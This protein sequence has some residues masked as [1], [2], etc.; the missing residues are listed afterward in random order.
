MT[1]SFTYKE[2]GKESISPFVEST[3]YSWGETDKQQAQY[4]EGKDKKGPLSVGVTLT[5]T[6][7]A[8]DKLS[9]EARLVVFGDVNFVQNAF[10][11]IPGNRQIVLNAVA[12]LTEQENLI[13]LPPRNDHS[14]VLMLSSTQ[15][16]YTGLLIVIVLPGLVLAAGIA[17]W[18][19]RKKL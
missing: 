15:M 4:D 11:G 2:G 16:N 13:H 6:I 9:N 12:W 14:D 8:K 7:D 1:R 3:Q 5:K 18:I 10:V 19:R 17:I